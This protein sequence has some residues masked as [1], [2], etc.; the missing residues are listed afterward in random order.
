LASDANI[1]ILSNHAQKD[2][3]GFLKINLCRMKW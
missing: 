2:C 1:C 3:W